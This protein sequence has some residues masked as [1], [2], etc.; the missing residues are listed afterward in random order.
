MRKLAERDPVSIGGF[1]LLGRLGAGGLGVVYLA[2]RDGVS[3]ALKVMREDLL[4]EPVARERFRREIEAL[5]RIESANVA[6]ILDHGFDAEIAWFAMEF[7]DGPTLDEHV[8][9]HGPLPEEQWLTFADGLLRGLADIHRQGIVHRDIK[10]SNVILEEGTPKIIDFGISEALEATSLT[11]TGIV[12]GSPAWFAPEQ[13]DGKEVTT[14]TD[15]FA[16][17]SVLT[18]A[19][20]TKT[21]WGDPNGMTR[22][23]ALRIGEGEPNL[24]GLSD[25]QAEL[26]REL[27]HPDPKER[28]NNFETRTVPAGGVRAQAAERGARIGRRRAVSLAQ[29]GLAIAAS[30]VGFS[31]WLAATLTTQEEHS[32]ASN[33]SLSSDFPEPEGGNSGIGFVEDFDYQ[34][35]R[36]DLASELSV[37]GCRALT[38]EGHFVCPDLSKVNPSSEELGPAPDEFFSKEVVVAE[39]ADAEC[40]EPE[41]IVLGNSIQRTADCT[42]SVLEQHR[43]FAGA[44]KT[45]SPPEKIWC[46]GST[47]W[48][49]WGN[50]VRVYV[51]SIYD[52]CQMEKSP[53]FD[54][55]NPPPGWGC[56]D[57]ML[58]CWVG[59]EIQ[60]YQSA[61]A[62]CVPQVTTVR[63]AE[64]STVDVRKIVKGS[65]T[66]TAE[67]R[68]TD[69]MIRVIS[70]DIR[71][72]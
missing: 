20:T 19:A 68:A 54:P 2:S 37:D 44:Q 23:A 27:I 45:L 56:I 9:Q 51:A 67:L 22:A 13:I 4:D 62:A 30:L 49:D 41:R 66:V 35:Q 38:A 70:Q 71:V 42:W 31:V 24:G 36:L 1:S 33:E 63:G 69:D 60:G 48:C 15:L 64:I 32:E 18:Y 61:W 25:A 21:P 72:G 11:A 52:R 53:N 6:R 57:F 28:R 58:D 14:S 50:G 29:V 17:G 40:N 12:A 34:W 8:K 10:P 55:G 16:A 39:A 47:G 7:I 26:V 43:Y 46:S 5:T 65:V 3:V 59:V